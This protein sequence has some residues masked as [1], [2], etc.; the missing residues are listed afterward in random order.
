MNVTTTAPRKK[1]YSVLAEIR[2]ACNACTCRQALL[3]W[4]PLRW[5][6][7]CKC[8]V[9]SARQCGAV[10]VRNARFIHVRVIVFQSSFTGTTIRY[11]FTPIRRRTHWPPRWHSGLSEERTVY[12]PHFLYRSV[13]FTE[14]EKSNGNADNA[15]NS[16]TECPIMKKS[17]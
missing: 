4:S 9:A 13:L 1:Q 14:G 11:C 12:I 17:T 5:H 6:R 7:Y 15:E 2:C 10:R 8:S 3:T 16:R